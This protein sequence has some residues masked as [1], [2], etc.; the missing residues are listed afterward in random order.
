MIEDYVIDMIRKYDPD[1]IEEE[2]EYIRDGIYIVDG[3]PEDVAEEI[4]LY[5]E[6]DIFSLENWDEQMKF[7]DELTSGIIKLL[8][9]NGNEC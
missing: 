8:E 9:E 7:K 6:D 3:T 2:A 1:F 4:Y 5:I